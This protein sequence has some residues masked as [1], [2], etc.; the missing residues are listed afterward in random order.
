MGD[1]ELR[2]K[3]VEQTKSPSGHSIVGPGTLLEV[4]AILLGNRI[5]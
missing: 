3:G 2:R 5:D 4:A 1:C